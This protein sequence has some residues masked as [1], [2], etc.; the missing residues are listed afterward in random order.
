MA[1]SAVI[2]LSD[3]SETCPDRDEL[4]YENGKRSANYQIGPFGCE[5]PDKS[6]AY[7]STTL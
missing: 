5:N 1:L 6:T 7:L 4:L 2:T 3:N